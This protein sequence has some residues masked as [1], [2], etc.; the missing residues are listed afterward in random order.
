M[1]NRFSDATRSE[2]KQRALRPILS[3]EAG[4]RMQVG[5]SRK[6]GKITIYSRPVNPPRILLTQPTVDFL[7]GYLKHGNLNIKLK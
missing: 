2:Q 4:E 5:P 3:K 6:H 7:I 1:L